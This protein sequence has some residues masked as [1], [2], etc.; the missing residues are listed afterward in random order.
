[1]ISYFCQLMVDSLTNIYVGTASEKILTPLSIEVSK[2][3]EKI[4]V[5]L[6]EAPFR[7]E[8]ELIKL[9]KID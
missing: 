4:K 8:K 9:N 6:L 2:V 7:V 5:K 1:M 3:S